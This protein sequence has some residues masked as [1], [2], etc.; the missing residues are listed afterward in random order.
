MGRIS[1]EGSGVIQ[2][3]LAPRFEPRVRVYFVVA[4]CICH[5]GALASFFCR[6]RCFACLLAFC[7]LHAQPEEAIRIGSQ[8]LF[9]APRRP[10]S[11]SASVDVLALSLAS[12]CARRNL[13]SLA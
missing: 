6:F 11:L 1:E 13:P 8:S 3:S 10:A 7:G 5:R 9:S 12:R 2:L 4:L